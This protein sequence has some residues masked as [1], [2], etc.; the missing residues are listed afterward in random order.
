[1]NPHTPTRSSRRPKSVND[2]PSMLGGESPTSSPDRS[3]PAWVPHRAAGGERSGIDPS[4]VPGKQRAGTTAS[5]KPVSAEPPNSLGGI[6][7]E[8]GLSKPKL[9]RY[10][11]TFGVYP[12]SFRALVWRYLLSLPENRAAHDAFV[13]Q[14]VH[15]AF[16]TFRDAFPI[17]APALAEATHR[18][19]SALAHWSPLFAGNIEYLPHLVF[20]LVKVAHRDTVVALELVLTVIRNFCQKWWEY[21]PNAPIETLEFVDDAL[22]RFDPALHAHLHAAA[23]APAHVYAWPMLTSLFSECLTRDAWLRVWDHLVTA[24]VTGPLPPP[25]TTET[26]K[27]VSLKILPPPTYMY[28]FVVAFLRHFRVALMQLASPAAVRDWVTTPRPLSEAAVLKSMHAM[29]RAMSSDPT[30]RPRPPPPG[31]ETPGLAV[32]PPTAAELGAAS[33]ALFTPFTPL[34]HPSP[35]TPPSAAAGTYPVFSGFP[36]AVVAYATSLHARL[37]HDEATVLRARRALR[38]VATLRADLDRDAHAWRAAESRSARAMRAWWDHVLAT[39]ARAWEKTR[40]ARAEVRGAHVAAMRAVAQAR[41]G[42]AAE[43]EARAEETARTL[44]GAAARAAALAELRARDREED[45]EVNGLRSAWDQRWTELKRAR[46]EAATV[47]RERMAQVVDKIGKMAEAAEGGSMA[48]PTRGDGL[49]EE[50]PW[51]VPKRSPVKTKPARPLAPSPSA[52]SPRAWSEY[53]AR[54]HRPASASLAAASPRSRPAF[55]C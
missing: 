25:G 50:L 42:Y 32:R 4:S 21:F 47:E 49:E 38:D 41:A 18:V 36:T 44:A 11:T 6:M 27:R 17:R 7:R 10:L 5:K 29:A 12:E 23:G 28:L 46:E 24:A 19:L 35:G 30:S 16:A 13:A 1:M 8:S 48:S 31:P 34:P 3:R 22:A 40:T 43:A 53:G 45:E 9:R 20:P 52:S 14:G 39:E 54:H 15:P 2:F 26:G 33:F 51:M 37:R 55:W